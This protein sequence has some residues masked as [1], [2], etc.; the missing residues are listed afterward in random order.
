[1]QS[2]LLF[3]GIGESAEN[4]RNKTFRENMEALVN[5]FLRNEMVFEESNSL[6]PD[7]I[8]F[9]RIHRLGKPKFDRQGRLLRP[10]PII[11]AFTS[12]KERECVRRASSTIK[13]KRYSV[14]EQFPTELEERRKKLY[15]FMKSA[16]SDSNNDIKLVRD[17]P[18]INGTTFTHKDILEESDVKES[19]RE[20]KNDR[21][22]R[23]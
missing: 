20:P 3:F 9:D 18:T 13:N 5:D 4:V 10:R 6:D 22:H 19:G 1:M 8:R 12:F 11:T 2:N 16:K 17:K 14:R 15:P 23:P 7:G 21:P